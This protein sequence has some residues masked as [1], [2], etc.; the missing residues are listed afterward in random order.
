MDYERIQNTVQNRETVITDIP[1][2]IAQLI[3][4]DE[5]LTFEQKQEAVTLVRAWCA[6]FTEDCT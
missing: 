3:K 5:S 1:L 6:I 2:K 4:S